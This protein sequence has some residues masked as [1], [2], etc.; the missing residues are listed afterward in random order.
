MILE[1]VFRAS[2][3]YPMSTQLKRVYLDGYST[4]KLAME[5]DS[6]KQVDNAM[7]GTNL[8]KRWKKL[9]NEGYETVAPSFV[10]GG[11]RAG[12][13][14]KKKIQTVQV[15]CDD[16]VAELMQ[17]NHPDNSPEAIAQLI[18]EADADALTGRNFQS[19]RTYGQIRIPITAI[20]S[21][22]ELTLQIKEHADK[23]K[24]LINKASVLEAIVLSKYGVPESGT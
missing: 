11:A 7:L 13:G 23:S 16:S 18:Q 6:S 12:S 20:A 10:R 3:W 14:R 15:Y 24:R 5:Q 22:E 2:R 19:V 9:N 21:L 8:K 1:P 17:V 4:E